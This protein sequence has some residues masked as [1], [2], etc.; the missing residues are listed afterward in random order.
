VKPFGSRSLCEGSGPVA[1][2]QLTALPAHQAH[3]VAAAAAI[4]QILLLDL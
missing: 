2:E 3:E 1:A 4:V